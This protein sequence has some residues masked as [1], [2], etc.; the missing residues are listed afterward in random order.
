MWNTARVPPECSIASDDCCSCQRLPLRSDARARAGNSAKSCTFRQRCLLL[1]LSL[2]FCLCLGLRPSA[3]APQTSCIQCTEQDLRAREPTLDSSYEEFTFDHQ[4]SRKEAI[5]ALRK[6]NET[7]D[8][9]YNACHSIECTPS[10]AKYCL[11]S[12]FIK[13][14]CW[15]ENQHGEEGVP[16]VPHICYVGE[17]VYAASVGSCFFFE[18]VKECCCAPVLV[19][20]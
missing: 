16:Y 15:C 3:A 20:E 2:Y 14:H 13:D 5:E 10:I 18:R 1:S 19:K 17:K 6:Y 9:R 4:V 12:Q 11:G 7:H 8:S